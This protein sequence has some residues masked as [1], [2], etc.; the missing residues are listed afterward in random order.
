MEL[1]TC[2]CH[3]AHVINV[4]TKTDY[5]SRRVHETFDLDQ[6]LLFLVLWSMFIALPRETISWLRLDVERGVWVVEI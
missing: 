1:C 2:S 6:I 3:W 4:T 5:E